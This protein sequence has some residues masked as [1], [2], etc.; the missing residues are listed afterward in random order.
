MTLA[1]LPLIAGCSQTL[2]FVYMLNWGAL[3]IFAPL[4]AAF[5]A[6]TLDLINTL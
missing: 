2:G 4:R 1:C 5:G 3:I 6:L